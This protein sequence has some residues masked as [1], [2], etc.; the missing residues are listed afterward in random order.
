M[1]DNQKGTIPAEVLEKIDNLEWEDTTLEALRGF[2]SDGTENNAPS[3]ITLYGFY[4]ENVT[5]H[6]LI[7]IFPDDENAGFRFQRAAVD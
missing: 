5:Q 2:K 6:Y 4:P 1:C 3:G 7:F